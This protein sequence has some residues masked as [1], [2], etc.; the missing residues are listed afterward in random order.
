VYEHTAD[1]GGGALSVGYAWRRFGI[2]LG[3][4]AMTGGEE[5]V[6]VI[7]VLRF[8]ARRRDVAVT[9]GIGSERPAHALGPGLFVNVATDRRGLVS[10]ELESGV[11]LGGP[12]ME[13]SFQIES[14]LVMGVRISRDLEVRPGF[15]LSAPDVLG[16]PGYQS[17]LGLRWELDR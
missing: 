9:W 14:V 15:G 7:P 11:Y 1:L 6:G 4:G 10:F 13:Q 17:T 5:R 16:V 8:V 3:A 2:E 12:A